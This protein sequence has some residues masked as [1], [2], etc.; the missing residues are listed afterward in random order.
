M[1]HK[2]NIISCSI[3]YNNEGALFCPRR[4]KKH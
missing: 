4:I 1:E 2:N 3:S